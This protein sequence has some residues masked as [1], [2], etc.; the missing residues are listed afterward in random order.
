MARVCSGAND[1]LRIL[2]IVQSVRQRFAGVKRCTS[3]GKFVFNRFCDRVRAAKRAP[4]ATRRVLERRH[5]L[6][7]NIKN[8]CGRRSSGCSRAATSGKQPRVV[9]IAAMA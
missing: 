7:S 3:P 9:H 4:R 2:D 1:L 8:C 6:R 5:G